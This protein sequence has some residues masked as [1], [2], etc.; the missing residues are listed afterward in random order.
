MRLISFDTF[1]RIYQGAVE[2]ISSYWTYEMQSEISRHCFS[3]RPE[4]FDFKKY[5]KASSIRYYYAYRSF[6]EGTNYRSLC[7][8]GGF[9]GVF[10]ITMKTL[11]ADVY[12]TESLKYYG[13]AFTALFSYISGRG[14]RIIDYDPFG[15]EC[16]IGKY[17]FVTVMAV[18]EHYP[19]SLRV[20][21]NNLCT[22]M[23]AQGRLYIEVPNIAYWP[24]RVGLLRGRTPLA[25]QYDIYKSEVPFIGH[26]H[27][28]TISELRNLVHLS[29]LVVSQEYF[30][31][32]SP[33]AL[34]GL[35]MLFCNPLQL[36]SWLFLA[37]SRECLAVLCAFKKDQTG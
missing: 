9:W 18:L 15:S 8:V 28:F 30:Y 1:S 37:D 13:T 23:K 2:Q 34:P 35:R 20:L 5:L 22:M 32:Y 31:N 26:H 6:S 12:M 17:D 16:P 19:H 3:W 29:G 24:K 4:L 33:G 10:A 11:G 7:D 25:P 27:E 36:I 21:M 14:V